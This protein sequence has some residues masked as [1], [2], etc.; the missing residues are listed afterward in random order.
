MREA[1]GL[2]RGIVN[3]DVF[4][5]SFFILFLNKSDLFEQKI[6][7]YS[8]KE[9]FKDFEGNEVVDEVIQFFKQ[10]FKDQIRNR[11]DER[12]KEIYFHV[13][14]ATDIS[15]SKKMFECIRTIIYGC[16]R[17]ELSIKGFL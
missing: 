11:R 3:L 15:C 4:K 5:D 14:C 8:V 13:T 16:G 17:K 2:F 1:I 7:K 6:G 12:K 9:H 10:K